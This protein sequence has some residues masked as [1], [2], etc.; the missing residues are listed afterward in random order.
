MRALTL[1]LFIATLVACDAT[2]EPVEPPVEA[3]PAPLVEGPAL[4]SPN[5]PVPDAAELDIRCE[6]GDAEACYSLSERFHGGH[7]VVRDNP[8]SV[9]YAHRACEGGLEWAC[10]DL[11]ARYFGGFEVEAD[12][13]RAY[14]YFER[15]C[16]AAIGEGC[17][18]LGRAHREGVGAEVDVARAQQE[19]ERSCA[20]G[21]AEGCHA[22]GLVEWTAG[23]SV[24][25]LPEDA[26]DEVLEAARA[27]D[28][29]IADG[30]R[31]LGEAYRDG[32]G[33]AADPVRADDAFHRAEDGI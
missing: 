32:D 7:G 12:P 18:M 29:A 13:A 30:C 11:G 3:A 24:S 6:A 27:C 19:F 10:Y 22:A 28:A 20:L 23:P 16:A 31:R 17:Y 5:V 8:R 9:R 21:V 26:S 4:D 15:T 14:G 25:A 1:L 2:D 33:V